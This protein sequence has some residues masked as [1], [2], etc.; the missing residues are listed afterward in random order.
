MD[1][2]MLTYDVTTGT[3]LT[4]LV[5]GTYENVVIVLVAADGVDA[6][7]SASVVESASGEASN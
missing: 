1:N 4:E 5:P 2:T 3:Q 6:A 7:T